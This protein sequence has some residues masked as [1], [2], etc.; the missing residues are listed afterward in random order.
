MQKYKRLIKE[1]KQIL[2]LLEYLTNTV[3]IRTRAI[4]TLHAADRAELVLSDACV[5][6]IT[7]Q[8]VLALQEFKLTAR[9]DHVDVLFLA[10][11]RAAEKGAKSTQLERR[12]ALANHCHQFIW[13]KRFPLHGA[14]VA[15]A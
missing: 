7:S 1:I 14:T 15:T 11:D 13:R 2:L 12:F 5:E 4:K 9:N 6:M 8:F 10:A 3:G